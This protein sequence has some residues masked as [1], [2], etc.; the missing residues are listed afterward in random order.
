[1]PK[2]LIVD[3]N[4][5]N[6]MLFN[7]F[8]DFFSEEENIELIEAASGAEAV[9]KTEEFEPDLI[10]MDIKMESQYAGLDAVRTIREKEKFVTTPIWAITSQ[11]MEANGIDQGDEQKCL[12]AGC[13]EYISKPFDTVQLIQ[14][15]SKL[16]NMEIPPLLK[17][18]MG[19]E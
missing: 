9:Q 6:R 14:M 8:F 7:K 1:M 13:N 18:R 12:A 11:A 10:L 4:E 17:K 15:I 2:V 5:N 16:L 19:I 3:D